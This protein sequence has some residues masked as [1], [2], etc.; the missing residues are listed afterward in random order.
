MYRDIIRF[1]SDVSPFEIGFV[2]PKV[3]CEHAA[4]NYNPQGILASAFAALFWRFWWCQTSNTPNCIRIQYIDV[5]RN[6]INDNYIH[7]L[8]R[9]I[10]NHI[11]KP[12]CLDILFEPIQCLLFLTDDLAG[13]MFLRNICDDF[14]YRDTEYHPLIMI[15]KLIVRMITTWFENRFHFAPNSVLSRFAMA[16]LVVYTMS[17][18]CTY[19]YICRYIY[20][21]D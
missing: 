15:P 4:L 8:S 12:H 5:T 14:V 3:D 9:R 2:P 7:F 21:Y 11:L 18:V 1:V 16:E 13:L 6:I 19:I 17:Y 20:V 10:W